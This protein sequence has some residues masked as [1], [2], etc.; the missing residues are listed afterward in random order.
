[1]KFIPTL[2]FFFTGIFSFSQWTKSTNLLNNNL[3][4][5]EVTNNGIVYTVGTDS[6]GAVS[7]NGIIFKSLDSGISWDTVYHGVEP[8]FNT[9]R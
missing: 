8:Q 1:M 7:F 3:N 4:D 2:L 6:S 9:V 5:I